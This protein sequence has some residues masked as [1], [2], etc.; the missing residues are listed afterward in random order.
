MSLF[1]PKH[2][3]YAEL[4]KLTE[5]GFGIREAAA[6]MRETQLPAAQA[7]LLGSV[8]HGLDNGL[9]IS[10]AFAASGT[11]TG[12]EETIIDAGER[13]GRLS[14]AFSHLADYFALV[15]AA[16]RQALRALAYPLLLLHLGIFIAI[17]PGGLIRGEPSGPLFRDVVLA[18]LLTYAAGF[19]AFLGVRALLRMAGEN[20]GVD[21]AI[22]RL[23]LIG[24][25]RRSMAM[26]RFTKV[27]HTCVLAGLNMSETAETSSRAARSGSIRAAGLL[28]ANH[29]REGDLLG[30]HFIASPVFPKA[31]S[32]SYATAEESG[33]LDR[34][35]A[36][37]AKLFEEDASAAAR[38]LAVALPKVLYLFIVA[39]VIWKILG[40]Y[41]NYY[42]MLD[43]IG[44]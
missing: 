22:N 23:P 39:F 13:G 20:A 1:G 12:L 33:M 19:L 37:W 32:R 7:S 30:P 24:G 43:N 40:F 3:F 28:L 42:E 34:D 29:A 31:F 41:G 14:A 26:A 9:S 15:H 11:L 35:L 18:L 38:T 10:R 25:A 16:R 36:R 2:H 17:V 8:D 4:A 27:Y 21:R 6:A 5:A 44:E